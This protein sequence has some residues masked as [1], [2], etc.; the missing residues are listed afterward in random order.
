M[1]ILMINKFLYP[2]GGA[3]TYMF[4]LGNYWKDQGAE[5]EYFGMQHMDNIV[6]NQWGIYTDPVDFR[7]KGLAS[8]VKNP[9]KVIYSLEAKRKVKEI[10]KLFEPDV[11]HIND[12]EAC[13]KTRR[14]GGAD[15]RIFQFNFFSVT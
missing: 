4:E 5:V 2:A 11:I 3:E 10:L 8:K 13:C 12:D 14:T 1:K 6:G 9:L 15:I 7:K